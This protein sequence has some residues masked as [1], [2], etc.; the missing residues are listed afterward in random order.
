MK[1]LLAPDGMLICLEFPTHKP[2]ASG[3]PPWALSPATYTELFKQPGQDIMYD[4]AGK[5]VQT[6]RPN[7]P[8]ALTRVAHYTPQRT[9]PVGVVQGVVRDFVSV[10]RHA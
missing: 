5:A 4:A 2:L 1:D 6:D 7:G 8:G 3:G 10:W 9:H